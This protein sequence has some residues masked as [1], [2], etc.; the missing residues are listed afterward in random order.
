MF[1]LLQ[2]TVIAIEQD[3]FAEARLRLARLL[4]AQGTASPPWADMVARAALAC[5]AA[6]AGDG[7][8]L[9]EALEQAAR[10]LGRLPDRDDT[11][12]LLSRAGALAAAEG[13]T[14]QAARATRMA[15]GQAERADLTEQIADLRARLD[16]LTA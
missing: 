12:V 14:E 4:P 10:S 16:A 13:L 5:C 3:D 2:L 7:D 8:T 1:C 6:H 9:S 15:L 11:L